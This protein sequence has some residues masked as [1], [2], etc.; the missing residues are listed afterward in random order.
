[1]KWTWI[2]N[3][4]EWIN[5]SLNNVSIFYHQILK[6]RKMIDQTF[7]I[8]LAFLTILIRKKCFADWLINQPILLNQNK[9]W[10]WTQYYSREYRSTF[11]HISSTWVTSSTQAYFSVRQIN[12]LLNRAPSKAT[13]IE[14]NKSQ[15][16][17]YKKSFDKCASSS[18]PSFFLLSVTEI[19]CFNS[20]RTPSLGRDAESRYSLFGLDHTGQYRMHT[21]ASLKH[22]L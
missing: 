2:S 10:L 8:S 14:P 18:R 1:M 3:G 17:D 6:E 5:A 22:C 7:L 4:K 15:S 16:G 20:Q 12:Q 13:F 11:L 9:W 21:S 19:A